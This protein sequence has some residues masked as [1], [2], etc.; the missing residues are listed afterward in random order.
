MQGPLLVEQSLVSD[1]YT[2]VLLDRSTEE[3]LH[4]LDSRVPNS[5]RSSGSSSSGERSGGAGSWHRAR[6]R[7]LYKPQRW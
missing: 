1:S 6:D 3:S 5:W 4:F 7:D 2:R